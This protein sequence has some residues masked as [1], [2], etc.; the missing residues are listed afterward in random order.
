ME[1]YLARTD[2]IIAAAEAAV[3]LRR[4][5]LTRSREAE[6]ATGEDEAVL[7]LLQAHL[8]ALKANRRMVE[9]D[10][11]ARI[12]APPPRADAGDAGKPPRK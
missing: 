8:A 12:N 10:F 6:A 3:A 7:S 2:R 9:A 11:T 4:K 5:D 1:T